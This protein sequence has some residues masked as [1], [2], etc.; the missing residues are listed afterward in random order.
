M[1]STNRGAVRQP[2]DHYAT[3]AW[4]TRAILPYL[5]SLRDEPDGVVLEPACG[6]GAIARVLLDAGVAPKRLVLVDVDRDRA[7]AALAGLPAG[8]TS[9]VEDF[10]AFAARYS[11]RGVTA[12]TTITNP[13]YSLAREFVDAALSIRAPGGVVAMLLRLNFL[14]SQKRAAW[15]RAHPADVYVLP[16]RPSFTESLH[17]AAARGETRCLAIHL[18]NM[19]K[20]KP[21]R[22][23]RATGHDGTCMTIGTD[24]CEYAWF[25]WTD[26][27]AARGAGLVRVLE[28][29]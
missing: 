19:V 23:A 16:R 2:D 5:P 3:P 22:C 8:V 6:E 27:S 7:V 21:S 15:H 9:N 12:R 20:G 28:V 29:E 4:A 26:E 17:W 25:C 13:P 18:A 24:S 1:S 11:A 10:I 14:G